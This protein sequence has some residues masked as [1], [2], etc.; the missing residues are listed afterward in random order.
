MAVAN[1]SEIVIK[2]APC[3]GVIKQAR[4]A[5]NTKLTTGGGTLALAKG[6]VNILSATNVD[7]QADLANATSELVDL[8][9]NE[10][11]LKVTAGDLLKATWTLTTNAVTNAALCEI[12]IEP[13][14]W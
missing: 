14:T 2:A 4:V 3:N 1:Q 7:L 13:S 9:A 10:Q 5:I 12:A 8:S 6:S 11:D